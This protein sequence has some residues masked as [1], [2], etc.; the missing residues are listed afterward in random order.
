MHTHVKDCLGKRSGATQLEIQR[1]HAEAEEQ[2][3]CV[4]EVVVEVDEQLQPVLPLRLRTRL[5][6]VVAPPHRHHR[7]V[8]R[9][10]QRSR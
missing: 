9:H 7:S 4:G 8:A 1:L 10:V 5:K 2:G 6:D 3:K